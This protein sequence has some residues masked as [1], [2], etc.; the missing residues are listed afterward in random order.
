M[1]CSCFPILAITS[2]ANDVGD[3]PDETEINILPIEDTTHIIID[4]WPS[5]D[6]NSTSEIIDFSDS[7]LTDVVRSSSPVTPNDANGLKKILLQ[8]IGDYEMVVNEYT[9]TSS[10]GYTNKQVTTEPDYAWISSCALFVIM[11][12]CIFRLFGGLINGKR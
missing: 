8:L 10:Q 6:D 1:F 7:V 3:I 5:D 2:F 11:I 4:N 9:Y 12:F